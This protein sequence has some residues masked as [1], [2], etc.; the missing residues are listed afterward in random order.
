MHERCKKYA[1][2]IFTKYAKNIQK[3]AQNMQKLMQQICNKYATNMQ[4]LCQ[5]Y[6]GNM[7]KK[8]KRICKI[9][10]KYTK[11]Y[12]QY[13][14]KIETSNMQKICKKKSNMQFM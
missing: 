11:I 3:Y 4:Q 12:I 10:A 7:P 13:A 9:Y 2:K 14:K 8:S 1:K 6:A 5:K